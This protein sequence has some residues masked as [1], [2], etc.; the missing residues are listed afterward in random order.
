MEEAAK[1]YEWMLKMKNIYLADNNR[2]SIAYGKI[3][4]NSIELEQQKGKLK[5]LK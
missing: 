2:M 3:I 4:Q 1:F 5:R